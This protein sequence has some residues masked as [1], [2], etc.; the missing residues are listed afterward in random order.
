MADN[1]LSTSA[2]LGE[3][4]SS[5]SKDYSYYSDGKKKVLY[6]KPQSISVRP[7]KS[8]SKPFS[9]LSSSIPS[10]KNYPNL[11]IIP[12]AAKIAE[13]IKKYPVIAID[14]PTGTGKTRYIPYYMAM[15][16]YKVRVAVP[17]TVAV[18]DSYRF[19]KK[20][21]DLQIG[22]AAGR[23]IKYSDDDQLIYATTG[24]FTQRILYSIKTG[25]NEQIRQIFGDIFVIDEVHTSTSQITLLIGLVKHLFGSDKTG[26]KIVFSTATFNRGDIIDYYPDFPTYKIDFDKEGISIEDIYLE[27]RR[28]PLENDPNFLI[29]KFAKKE[30]ELWKVSAKKYHGIVFRP[31]I[32][33][34]EEIGRAHV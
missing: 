29:E 6:Q 9:P 22:F 16:G 10:A 28:N 15:Q 5:S 20:Y 19:Q 17:T 32:G 24:H 25:N 34:V 23:E 26:P 4:K 11:K 21:S 18:R 7:F 31:G 33:E 12:H 3:E 30:L 2:F 13:Y 14:A 1:I 8:I 27:D